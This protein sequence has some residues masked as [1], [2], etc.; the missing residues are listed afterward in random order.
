[1]E[2]V[3]QSCHILLE[4]KRETEPDPI[5]AAP[6]PASEPAVSGNRD[7]AVATAP[8]RVVRSAAGEPA[9]REDAVEWL[10]A[11]ARYI[12]RHQPESPAPYLM[13]RGFRWG[14]LR[15]NGQSIDQTLLEPPPTEIR[16][17]LKRLSL[18]SNWAELLEA[19]ETAMGKS[20]GRGWLDLQRYVCRAC[21]ELGRS[22]APIGEAVKSELRTLLQDLPELPQMTLMDDTATATADTLAWL[23]DLGAPQAG[24]ASRADDPGTQSGAGASPDPFEL[25]TRAV[26]EGRPQEGLEILNRE[27]ARERSGRGR[28]HRKVQMAELCLSIGRDAIAFPLLNDLAAEIE[29][30][31]LEE[32]E[33]PDA[34]AHPLSLL[35]RCLNKMEAGTEEKQRLYDRICRLDPAQAMSCVV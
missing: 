1:V 33:P 29:L 26:A 6:P 18:Q 34:V 17:Q 28:F 2:E 15:S 4:K 16:Q 8:V 22:Y 20:Y 31:K 25:A 9:D 35:F 7:S 11:A 3:R 10:V 32:W 12:R 13:L 30:R 24:A 19:A 21:A 23:R 14:E 27:L 5:E